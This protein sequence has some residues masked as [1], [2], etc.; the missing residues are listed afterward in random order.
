MSEH[1]SGVSQAV[2][3]QVE[4]RPWLTGLLIDQFDKTSTSDAYK[5]SLVVNGVRDAMNLV[6]PHVVDP[7]VTFLVSRMDQSSLA[8]VREIFKPT[9]IHVTYAIL[10]SKVQRKPVKPDNLIQI[11]HSTAQVD[12]TAFETIQSMG[13]AEKSQPTKLIRSDQVKTRAAPFDMSEDGIF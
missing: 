12:W 1:V 4:L 7:S 13:K 11:V 6:K 10:A 5:R 2:Q 9:L 8:C 3:A